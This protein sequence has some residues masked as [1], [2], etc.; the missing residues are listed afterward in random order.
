M[1][2]LCGNSPARKRISNVTKH[3]E[4]SQ[5]YARHNRLTIDH[6]FTFN[7]FLP[8]DKNNICLIVARREAKKA[9]RW[10]YFPVTEK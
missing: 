7:F 4:R 3:M 2:S 6:Q 5:N 10:R 1:M 9:V 8:S